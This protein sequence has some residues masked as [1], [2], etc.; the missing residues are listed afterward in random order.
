MR[1]ILDSLGL[2]AEAERLRL[3]LATSG[4][5]YLRPVPQSG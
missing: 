4:Y 2:S 3:R 5:P 1:A